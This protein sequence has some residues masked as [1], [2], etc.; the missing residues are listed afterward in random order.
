MAHLPRY[1][2]P[3]QPQHVIQRGNDRQPIFFAVE[4]Y[5]RYLDWLAKAATEHGSAVHAYVLM[6][7]H[8]HLLISPRV[9]ESIPRTLQSLQQGLGAGRRAL[10]QARGQDRRPAHR[11]A[12]ARPAAQGAGRKER[13]SEAINRL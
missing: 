9:A 6:T 11:A 10:P 12:A 2:L 5:A 7:N 1:F 8:V 3:D 13:E 4:D